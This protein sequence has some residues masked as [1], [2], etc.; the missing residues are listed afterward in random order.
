MARVRCPCTCLRS[1]TI[2]ER[3]H[4]ISGV[5]IKLLVP[6]DVGLVRKWF[7]VIF[8]YVYKNMLLL[9]YQYIARDQEHTRQTHKWINYAETVV[10]P[11]PDLTPVSLEIDPIAGWMFTK[12]FTPPL[13][14][15]L[16]GTTL[17]LVPNPVI[18]SKSQHFPLV[19][20]YSGLEDQNRIEATSRQ[21]LVA[22]SASPELTSS[23]SESLYN[24]H[25]ELGQ[26][27]WARPTHHLSKWHKKGWGASV[28]RE[29]AR[30]PTEI[31]W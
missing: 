24:S 22:D 17:K 2:I 20:Q 8:L 29:I 26:L 27:T 1:S 23:H 4:S 13:W 10:L 15:R 11:W 7:E 5:F 31:D 28:N 16:D 19:G 21:K 3:P 12:S 9:L 14:I 6:C 18:H 30:K 25:H